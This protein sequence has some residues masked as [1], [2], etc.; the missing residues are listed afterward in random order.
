MIKKNPKK[1]TKHQ[2][3]TYKPQELNFAFLDIY[4]EHYSIQI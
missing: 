1:P 3:Q 4:R 2:K